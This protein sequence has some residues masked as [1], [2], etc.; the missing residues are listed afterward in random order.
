MPGGK[1]GAGGRFRAGR[2]GFGKVA[3]G[4]GRRRAQ[5]PASRPC[6]GGK[7]ARIPSPDRMV[8][9]DELGAVR[10][11]RLHLNGM[12]HLGDA[13]HALIGADH[14]AARLH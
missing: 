12:D 1:T 5:S 4:N 3:P 11:G 10:E 2:D 6:I 9:G 13:L 7:P 14:M 8:D